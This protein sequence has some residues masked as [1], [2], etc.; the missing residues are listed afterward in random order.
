MGTCWATGSWATGSWG[1]GTW[2]DA[3]TTDNA[4]VLMKQLRILFI[5]KEADRSQVWL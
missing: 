2:A 1:V 3:G 4:N 5:L